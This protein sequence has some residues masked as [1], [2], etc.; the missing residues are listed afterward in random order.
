MRVGLRIDEV[1]VHLQ[2][3]DDGEGF[4]PLQPGSGL[5][6]AG[7]RE[8]TERLGG[9]LRLESGPG[10]GTRVIVEVPR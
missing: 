7:M 4:D 6:L 2:I 1:R 8:R 5:G 9:S 10:Q 3:D